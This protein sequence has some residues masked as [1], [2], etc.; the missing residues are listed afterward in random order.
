VLTLYTEK[1]YL[2]L[3]AYM[4]PEPDPIN[5]VYLYSEQEIIKVLG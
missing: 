1:G 3:N 2:G 5:T 4:A